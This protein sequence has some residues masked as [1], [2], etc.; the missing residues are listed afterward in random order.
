VRLATINPARVAAIAG[1]K[2][3]IAP[4]ADADI[5]VLTPAGEVIQTMVRGRTAEA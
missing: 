3:K 4:G 1:R 5:I 2:G